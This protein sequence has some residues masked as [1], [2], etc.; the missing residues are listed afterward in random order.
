VAKTKHSS[1]Y[2]EKSPIKTFRDS[3]E[4]YSNRVRPVSDA[5]LEK[6]ADYVKEWSS[7]EDSF[8]FNQF[9][10]E[11]GITD[12]DYNEWKEKNEKLK[13]EHKF[14]LMRLASRREIG[15]IKNQL[16]T[17][18]IT[19]A[20][21]MYDPQWEKETVRRSNLTKQENA[22]GATQTQFVLVDKIPDSSLVKPKEE[23]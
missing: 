21:P 15:A 18:M 16:N 11:T 19:F 20:M 12:S 13:R 8:T 6:T 5:F 14:A 10:V 1:S 2:K 23:E 22:A 4:F 3:A 9:F 17:Q 7:R